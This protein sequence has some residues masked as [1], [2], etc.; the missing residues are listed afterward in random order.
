MLYK[1]PPRD[2]FIIGILALL[3]TYSCA[4]PTVVTP[5]TPANIQMAQLS[6]TL[7]DAESTASKTLIALR[8]NSKITQSETQMVQNYILVAA[9]TGKAMD[10]ELVSADDWPTQKSK[11]VQMWVASGIGQAKASL[12]PTAGLVLDSILSVINQIMTAIGGPAI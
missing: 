8:D 12:S 6:K 7:A 5:V 9:T 2:L 3:I 1:R 11:I 4:K 10:A